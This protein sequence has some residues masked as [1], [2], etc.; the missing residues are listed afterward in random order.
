[1][2]NFSQLCKKL[3]QMDSTTSPL[4]KVLSRKDE[5][6]LGKYE[7]A[8]LN[9][10]QQSFGAAL[11]ANFFFLGNIV[12]L[13]LSYNRKSTLGIKM[14][15]KD[16]L[17]HGFGMIIP[18]NVACLGMYWEYFKEMPYLNYL[19]EKYHHEISELEKQN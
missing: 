16:M 3:Q 1:M 6:E 18:L 19:E 5:Q 15:R 10:K 2:D 4:F 8:Y 14:G 12:W 7:K 13:G 17:K 11:V 9:R